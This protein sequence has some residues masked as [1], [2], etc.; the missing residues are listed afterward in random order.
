LQNVKNNIE[1]YRL[2][3]SFQ[4]DNL[5]IGMKTEPINYVNTVYKSTIT[6]MMPVLNSE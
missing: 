3:F 1:K 6:N 4:F 5:K 2:S